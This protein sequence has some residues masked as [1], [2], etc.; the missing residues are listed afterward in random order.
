MYSYLQVDDLYYDGN[1][2][3]SSLIALSRLRMVLCDLF[4]REVPRDTLLT[5]KTFLPFLIRLAH[6]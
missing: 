5:Q 6:F 4:V 3:C 1:L 2:L